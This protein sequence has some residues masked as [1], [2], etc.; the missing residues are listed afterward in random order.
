MPAS[1]TE[2]FQGGMTGSPEM[3]PTGIE[4]DS[5]LAQYAK[6]PVAMNAGSNE[7]EAR[8]TPSGLLPSMNG[9]APETYSKKFTGMPTQVGR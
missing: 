6:S 9:Y 7:A 4:P 3:F 1:R 2:N 8:L 5:V